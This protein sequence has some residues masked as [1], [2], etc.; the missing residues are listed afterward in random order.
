VRGRCLLVWRWMPVLHTTE[1]VLLVTKTNEEEEE[2]EEE[3]GK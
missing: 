2:E 1:K 3:E